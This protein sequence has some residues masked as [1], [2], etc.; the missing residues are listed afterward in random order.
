MYLKIYYLQMLLSLK[1]LFLLGG[2]FQLQP[3]TL[4]EDKN[5]EFNIKI[6]HDPTSFYTFIQLWLLWKYLVQEFP[7]VFFGKTTFYPSP[8]G[9]GNGGGVKHA[10]PYT[11]K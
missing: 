6:P 11:I 5:S 9:G 7:Y 8:G 3:V 1:N 4:I 2:R 10:K